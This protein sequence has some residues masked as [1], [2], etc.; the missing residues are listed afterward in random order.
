VGRGLFTYAGHMR[1]PM[2]AQHLILNHTFKSD[3]FCVYSE[4]ESAPGDV[5]Q[6][7]NAVENYLQ[8]TPIEEQ[9]NQLCTELLAADK[10]PYNP[11]PWLA[12]KF[13][14]IAQR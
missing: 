2:H 5:K 14:V 1:L 7:L 9:F 10:L 11:Y 6:R 13:Q 8:Q 4:M 3:D 12:N